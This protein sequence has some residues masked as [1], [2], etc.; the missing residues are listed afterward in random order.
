VRLGHG[1]PEAGATGPQGFFL[2]LARDD[3]EAEASA[4]DCPHLRHGGRVAVQAVD[5]T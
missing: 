5:P 1:P 3:A 4:R 2:V